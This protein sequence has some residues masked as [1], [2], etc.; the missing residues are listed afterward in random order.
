MFVDVDIYRPD[1]QTEQAEGTLC[2]PNNNIAHA[3]IIK[4]K[5]KAASEETPD[6]NY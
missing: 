5:L 6:A 4:P 2:H 3:Q 1:G